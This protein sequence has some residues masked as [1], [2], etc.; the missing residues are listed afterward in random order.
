[1]RSTGLGR[2]R[3]LRSPPALQ[4]MIT[5]H[6]RHF[7]YVFAAHTRRTQTHCTGALG[8]DLPNK[9]SIK[10]AS[11][12]DAQFLAQEIF[13]KQ[14][15]LQH[16]VTLQAGQTVVDVGANVGLFALQAADCTGEQVSVDPKQE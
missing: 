9:L 13:E 15:Y 2:S 4:V 1:M 16:G 10:F 12:Q 7:S 8:R 5:P 11:R 6:C 14:T 3:L